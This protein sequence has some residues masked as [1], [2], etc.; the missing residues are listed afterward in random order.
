[1][2]SKCFF[3]S[4]S[5]IQ[6]SLISLTVCEQPFSRSH[7]SLCM[8]K[9]ES[10]CWYYWSRPSEFITPLRHIFIYAPARRSPLLFLSFHIILLLFLYRHLICCIWAWM[11]PAIF[12][13]CWRIWLE[14]YLRPV[15]GILN[16]PP[17]PRPQ[18]FSVR[19][20][21]IIPEIRDCGCGMARHGL[22][23]LWYRG[24]DCYADGGSGSII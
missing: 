6:W 19:P 20:P 2:I 12:R 7:S 22:V 18:D 8:Y 10:E 13:H 9:V 1:M 15:G 17:P 3:R 21:L 16:T 23:R 11:R 14:R 24:R 5:V 4:I